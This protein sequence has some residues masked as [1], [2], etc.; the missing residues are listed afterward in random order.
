MSVATAGDCGDEYRRAPYLTASGDLSHHLS[1]FPPPFELRRGNRVS[2][3]TNW[4]EIAS[5]SRASI[6][7]G[8]IHI[9]HVFKCAYVMVKHRRRQGASVCLPALIG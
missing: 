6:L 3:G 1:T 9:S 7:S 4:E 5:F 8:A 2:S